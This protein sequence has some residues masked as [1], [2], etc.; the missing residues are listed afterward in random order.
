MIFQYIRSMYY[1]YVV[2]HIICLLSS[3]EKK[4]KQILLV[5]NVVM[6]F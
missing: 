6:I 4:N 1:I 3:S 5:L 2:D